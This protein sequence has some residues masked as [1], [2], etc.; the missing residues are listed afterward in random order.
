MTL[1]ERGSSSANRKTGAWKPK[2]G[3]S[4]TLPFLFEIGLAEKTQHGCKYDQYKEANSPADDT[5]G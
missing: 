2:A 3:P 5:D 1:I 4:L